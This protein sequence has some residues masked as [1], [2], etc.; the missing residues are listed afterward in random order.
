MTLASFFRFAANSISLAFLGLPLHFIS[1]MLGGVVVFALLVLWQGPH[2]KLSCFLVKYR[3]IL[4]SLGALV[5]LPPLPP[6]LPTPARAQS[7]TSLTGLTTDIGY[8]MLAFLVTRMCWRSD[9]QILLRALG[10]AAASQAFCLAT[11][12]LFS[13]ALCLATMFLMRFAEMTVLLPLKML[14]SIPSFLLSALADA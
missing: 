8:H 5:L 14:A 1:I 12:I 6:L 13:R 9:L 10:P 11:I 2:K 4:N 7:L 3:R